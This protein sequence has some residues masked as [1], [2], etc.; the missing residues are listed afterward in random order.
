MQ[1]HRGL[2][3]IPTLLTLFRL[4]LSPLVLPILLVYLLP[5][6]VFWINAALAFLFVIFSFTDFLDGYLARKY[7]QETALGRALDPIADKFLVYSVLIALQAA[8]KIY[9]YWV[10]LLIGREIFMMGLRQLA[11]EHN[12]SIPVS[13][14][15]KIKTAFQMMTIT[16]IILNPAQPL[17]VAGA[18]WWNGTEAV[19]LAVTIFLSLFSAY[20]YNKQ[21]IAE[22]NKRYR[23]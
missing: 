1:D 10:V 21:C 9:F 23:N 18:F 14:W 13:Y 12:F 19:F 17:G 7:R 3:N 11:L 20:Q 2:F 16:I 6:N 5:A 22:F 8:N 4:I 15:G